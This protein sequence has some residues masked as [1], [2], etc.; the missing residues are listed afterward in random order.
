MICP[1]CKSNQTKACAAAYEQGSRWGRYQTLSEL[2]IRCAPPEKKPPFGVLGLFFLYLYVIGS[3][4]FFAG[5][6]LKASD[7]AF[8]ASLTDALLNYLLLGLAILVGLLVAL[9][10]PRI[11][12]NRTLYISHLEKWN[13]KWVCLRCSLIFEGTRV[14]NE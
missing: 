12:Y 14:S 1:N 13:S 5:H 9:A 8:Y 4:I 7:S 11:I 6:L 10:I 3:S 2:A